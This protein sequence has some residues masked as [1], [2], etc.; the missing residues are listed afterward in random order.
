MGL[1]EVRT[2][3]HSAPNAIVNHVLTDAGRKRHRASMGRCAKYTR[4]N[5]RSAPFCS[6]IRRNL[7]QVEVA[8]VATAT[9]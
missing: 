8:A 5:R 4:K 1:T 2:N 3:G 7:Q 9:H 6:G